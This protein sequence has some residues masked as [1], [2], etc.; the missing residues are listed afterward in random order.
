[1]KLKKG[2]RLIVSLGSNF[3]PEE[4]I[5]CAAEKLRILFESICF[6]ESVYTNP[7]GNYPEDRPFLNQ[8][9][10]AYT[11]V[12][13]PEEIKKQLKEIE[14]SLGRNENSKLT[15]LI[16]VDIDLLQ[17]NEEVLKPSDMERD[18][19]ISGILFLERQCNKRSKE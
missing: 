5:Q 4:N 15:G 6:S 11:D 16:P 12:E 14:Y 10:I 3:N 18:Y 1:M 7:I 2:N 17:W 13:T 9:A 19:I 8:V